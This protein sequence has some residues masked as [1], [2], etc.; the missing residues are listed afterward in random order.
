MATVDTPPLAEEKKQEAQTVRHVIDTPVISWGLDFLEHIPLRDGQRILDVGCRDGRITTEIA[1]RYPNCEILAIES[2]PENA[3][4][5]EERLAKYSSKVEVMTADPKELWFSEGFDVAVSFSHLHWVEDKTAVMA[6][7]SNALK[8]AGMAYVQFFADHGRDR[9]DTCVQEVLKK[10]K[11]SCLMKEHGYKAPPFYE[12][13]PKTMASIVE[14]TGF[15]TLQA[16]FVRHHVAFSD[17]GAMANWI[18]S[19]CR[20]LPLVPQERHQ[21]FLKEV[22]EFYAQLHTEEQ[23]GPVHHYDYLLELILKKR[24]TKCD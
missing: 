1:R 8:P 10:S 15:E 7:I 9:F 4:K 16:E 13:S 6:S 18:A 12:I 19:W 24:D 5:A 22:I 14:E 11:W 21:E 2:D 17:R 3:K 20:H 23:K